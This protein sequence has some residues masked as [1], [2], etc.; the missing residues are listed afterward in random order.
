MFQTPPQVSRGG[1]MESL[2]L[3]IPCEVRCFLGFLGTHKNPPK[4]VVAKGSSE[5]KG[6]MFFCPDTQ[7]MVHLPTFWQNFMVNVG[8]YTRYIE[9]YNYIYTYYIYSY[10]LGPLPDITWVIT[11]ITRVKSP[12]L[13]NFNKAIYRGPMSF[14]L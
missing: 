9:C 1:N 2:V 13:P 12:H 6:Y 3:Q 5:H 14:H 4:P 11:P 8:K 10:K 7:C